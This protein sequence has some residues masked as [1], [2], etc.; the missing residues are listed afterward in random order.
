MATILKTEYDVKHYQNCLAHNQH[1][2]EDLK[3]TDRLTI[4]KESW[5]APMITFW[6]GEKQ[7]TSNVMDSYPQTK[8]AKIRKARS[9]LANAIKELEAIN[10]HIEEE[11]KGYKDVY[12]HSN[13][14]A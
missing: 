8:S 5:E 2:I 6:R 10:S 14:K 13:S 3:N 9:V 1:L 11:L 7:L 4:K 12:Q